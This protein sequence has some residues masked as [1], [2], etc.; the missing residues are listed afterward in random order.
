M[1]NSSSDEVLS[2]V[3]LCLV[4]INAGGLGVW[5]AIRFIRNHLKYRRFFKKHARRP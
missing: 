1:D 4:A 3:V 2:L 5:V